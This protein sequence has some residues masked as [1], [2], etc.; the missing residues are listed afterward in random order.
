MTKDE[1][2]KVRKENKEWFARRT[3]C[4]ESEVM[5]YRRMCFKHHLFTIFIKNDPYYEARYAMI[6][7][8]KSKKKIV[9]KYDNES[10]SEVLK[11]ACIWISN[12]TLLAYGPEQRID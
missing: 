7:Y 8:N 2:R 9:R 5:G 12:D 11:Y 1:K 3:S 10:L 4:R 6:I